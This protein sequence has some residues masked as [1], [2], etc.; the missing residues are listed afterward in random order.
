MPVKAVQCLSPHEKTLPPR[1]AAFML[2]LLL[3]LPL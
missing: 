1:C 2:L 3:L